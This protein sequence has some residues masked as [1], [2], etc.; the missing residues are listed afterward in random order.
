MHSPS[1]TLGVSLSAIPRSSS[2]L[3]SS[4][5]S[6]R[7]AASARPPSLLRTTGLAV[8]RQLRQPQERHQP[9]AFRLPSRPGHCF[10][11]RML[12]PLKALPRQRPLPVLYPTSVP[13][14]TTVRLLPPPSPTQPPRLPE[15]FS[16]SADE[17][18]LRSCVERYT[19]TYWAHEQRTEPHFERFFYRNACACV[20]Q[21]TSPWFPR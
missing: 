5:A 7:F 10:G 1:P 2:G 12:Q 19:Y 13:A 16:W 15:P 14:T 4:R 21:N 6:R 11:D 3:I 18:H 17:P 20:L 8:E 9:V